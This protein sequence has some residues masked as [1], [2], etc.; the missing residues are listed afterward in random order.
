ME[1][2]L[3]TFHSSLPPAS[4]PPVNPP[5]VLTMPD[6]DACDMG[7]N[8]QFCMGRLATYWDWLSR[9]RN[10][11]AAAVYQMTS[12]RL[13]YLR[14]QCGVLRDTTIMRASPPPAPANVP[15]V[16]YTQWQNDVTRNLQLDLTQAQKGMQ[17]VTSVFQQTQDTTFAEDMPDLSKSSAASA[18]W[19]T[20]PFMPYPAGRM[21]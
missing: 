21:P 19:P 1:T 8:G 2:T 20:F 5:V 12:E 13:Q 15:P 9:T 6:C 11:D 4:D 7:P 17:D 16:G 3:G 18:A 10:K 14:A